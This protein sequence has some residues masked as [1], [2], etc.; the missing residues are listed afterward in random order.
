MSKLGPFDYMPFEHNPWQPAATQ[1]QL[2]LPSPA[3]EADTTSEDMGFA[4]ME[5]IAAAALSWPL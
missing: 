4:E 5:R 1:L 3:K 2:P